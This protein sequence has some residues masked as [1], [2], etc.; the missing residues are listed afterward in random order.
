[1]RWGSLI[2]FLEEGLEYER[3]ERNIGGGFFL[4]KSAKSLLYQIL[5]QKRYQQFSEISR[6]G[7]TAQ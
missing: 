5:V 1:M 7:L 2:S 4:E 3:P 6:A